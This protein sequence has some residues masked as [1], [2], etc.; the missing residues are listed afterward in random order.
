M[1]LR[2]ADIDTYG[3]VNNAV[4][5]LLMD[6]LINGWLGEQTGV[7]IRSDLPG[8][9]VVVETGCVFFREMHFSSPLV[10]GLRLEKVSRSSVQYE[11]G[12]FI[13]GDEPAAV[14]RFV[15]VYIDPDSRR[16]VP[17]PAAVRDVLTSIGPPV[18]ALDT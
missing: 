15:H 14:G 12:F 7:D 13:D 4:N 1:A 8:F 6:T 16:P 10:L 2:W 17:V 5:Y 3:H 18:R 9:A 11:V